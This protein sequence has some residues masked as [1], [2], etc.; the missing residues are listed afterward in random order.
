MRERFKKFVHALSL[1]S[2]SEPLSIQYE[3]HSLTSNLQDFRECYI[4]S[5]RLLIYQI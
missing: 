1:F 2:S 4:E 3:D 5:D